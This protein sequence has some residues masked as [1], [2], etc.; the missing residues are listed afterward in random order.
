MDETVLYELRRTIRADVLA[1]V[2]EE[3]ATAVI[4]PLSAK[5]DA[6]STRV[7]AIS[8]TLQELSDE[9]RSLRRMQQRQI[10]LHNNSL[11]GR[12]EQVEV[13]PNMAGLLPTDATPPLAYPYALSFLLVAENHAIPP[14]RYSNHWSNEK[15]VS[16]LQFYNADIT[17][18]VGSVG[19]S[20]TEEGHQPESDAARANRLRLARVL[21]VSQAQMQLGAMSLVSV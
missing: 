14:Y 3:V 2:R 18:D 7:D 4:A 21:G 17:R 11:K 13:V 10:A 6:I 9:V 16:L 20:D 5:I 15:S 12:D 8:T 1:S 19:V